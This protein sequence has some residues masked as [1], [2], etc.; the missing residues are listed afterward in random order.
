MHSMTAQSVNVSR[1]EAKILNYGRIYGAGVPFA[2]QLLKN[3][4]PQLSDE[5]A[6][7]LA[8]KMYRFV[9]FTTEHNIRSTSIATWACMYSR[10]VITVFGQ[11]AQ[12]HESSKQLEIGVKLC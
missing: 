3:F 2:K 5:Q 8:L 9:P 7:R 10:T 6:A 12:N 4:N 11:K 1:N